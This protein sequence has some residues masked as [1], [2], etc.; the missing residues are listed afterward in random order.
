MCATSILSPT[1]WKL[2]LIHL[3]NTYEF[4]FL[5]NNNIKSY[6]VLTQITCL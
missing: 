3:E 6:N 2:K 4:L 5:K 1:H